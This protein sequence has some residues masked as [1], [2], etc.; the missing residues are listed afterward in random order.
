MQNDPVH[1]AR[2]LELADTDETIARAVAAEDTHDH[3]GRRRVNTAGEAFAQDWPYI[4]GMVGL[5]V[6]LVFALSGQIR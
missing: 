3:M 4:L 1:P 6:F 5:I 2:T